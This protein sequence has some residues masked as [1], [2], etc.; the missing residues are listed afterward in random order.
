MH[1]YIYNVYK[2]GHHSIILT[3][4]KNWKLKVRLS[5]TGCNHFGTSILLNTYHT[6]NKEGSYS[7]SVLK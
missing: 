3:V 1:I 4:K 6:I 2:D 7:A 5:K